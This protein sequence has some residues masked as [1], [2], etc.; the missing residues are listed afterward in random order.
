MKYLNEPEQ[1]ILQRF[2][3]AFSDPE[4]AFNFPIKYPAL[5]IDT[6]TKNSLYLISGILAGGMII[7]AL[8]IANKKR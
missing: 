6:P 4:K 8:I 3:D 5:T 2:A 7:G 1:T